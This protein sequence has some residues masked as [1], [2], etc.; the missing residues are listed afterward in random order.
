MRPFLEYKGGHPPGFVENIIYA[1][2]AIKVGFSIIRKEKI[3]IIQSNNFAPA[4]AGSILSF[5]TSK[6]HITVI[7][8]VFSFCKDF[9][10]GWAKQENVSRL[11]V[12]LA[13]FFEKMIIR[14]KCDAIHTV[15]EASRDDLIKFGA[16]KPIYVIHN[17]VHFETIKE[18]KSN[19]NQF[20]YIGRLVFY[21]NL[22]VVIKAIGILRKS[23]PDLKL[24]VIG[25]GPHR[26]ILM[27][28]VEN[29]NLEK[30]IIFKGYTTEEEKIRYLATSVSMIFPSF[31]EGFGLVT[32]EAFAYKKPVIVPDVRPLSDVV[33]NNKTGYVVP[34]FDQKEWANAMEKILKNP[35]EAR[36]MGNAGKEL[37]EKKYSIDIMENKILEMYGDFIKK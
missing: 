30:N 31:C 13:P 34:A 9:W 11:N 5:L 35:E 27:E 15:S 12:L 24:V 37:L 1:I 14:L 36:H 26:R 21:K 10:Q 16:K 6:P 4:L 19:P 7:H 3:D 23:Y 22:E 32:L 2:Y 29:L 17:T 28:L 25:D 33:E 8:D 18:L 20:V